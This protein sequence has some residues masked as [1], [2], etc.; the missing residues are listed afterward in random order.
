[1][2]LK[3]QN[4]ELKRF[5]KGNYDPEK[6]ISEFKRKW[7]PTDL[8]IRKIFLASD[9]AVNSQGVF[10]VSHEGFL[11]MYNNRF[12]LKTS[13]SSVRRFFKLM[14]DLGLIEVRHAKKKK[15]RKSVV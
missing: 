8:Q 14:K 12:E 4:D 3:G 6:F 10:S 13:L 7:E 11:E 1:M 9:L 5:S 2:E 15:D